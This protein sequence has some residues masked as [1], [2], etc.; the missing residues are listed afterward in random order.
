MD[1]SESQFDWAK[2]QEDSAEQLAPPNREQGVQGPGHPN[3]ELFPTAE[4]AAAESNE[5]APKPAKSKPAAIEPAAIEPG[6]PAPAAPKAPKAAKT[7]PPAAE[8]VTP[9]VSA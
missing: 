1:T 8:E 5:L 4:Q 9:D 3:P 6:H 2:A 7:P